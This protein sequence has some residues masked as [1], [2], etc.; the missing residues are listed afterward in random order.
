MHQCLYYTVNDYFLQDCCSQEVLDFFNNMKRDQRMF[1]IMSCTDYL[2]G[3]DW[4]D[5]FLMYYFW[6]RLRWRARYY[7]APSSTPECCEIL[8]KVFLDE[9]S[10]GFWWNWGY[11]QS[12]FWT[13]ILQ[14]QATV[15]PEIIK[16]SHEKLFFDIEIPDV[17]RLALYGW[18]VSFIEFVSI[19]QFIIYNQPLRRKLVPI[20]RSLLP[21]EQI[22]LFSEHIPKNF[23]MNN[24]SGMASNLYRSKSL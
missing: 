1:S 19:L 20:F 4:T 24:S 17:F 10:L 3:E 14:C 21:F 8:N 2:F 5:S 12:L 15:L 18:K 16:L 9:F 13:H 23:A 22:L 11:R 6:L 7:S